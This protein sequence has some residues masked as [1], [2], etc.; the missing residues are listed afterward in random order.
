[1][2]LR[3]YKKAKESANKNVPSSNDW[4]TSFVLTVRKLPA[5]FDTAITEPAM[6]GR[7]LPPAASSAQGGVSWSMA[8]KV[9]ALNPT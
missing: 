7:L 6:S 5:S 9:E 8:L 2:S 3:K 1:M 4:R